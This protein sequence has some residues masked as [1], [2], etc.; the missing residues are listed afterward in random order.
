MESNNKENVKGNN[1][2]NNK[3]KES[4]CSI[5]GQTALANATAEKLI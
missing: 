4:N 1:N 3:E 2:S 5:N